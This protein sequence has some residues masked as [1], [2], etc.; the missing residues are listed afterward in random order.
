MVGYLHGGKNLNNQTQLRTHV[1][2]QRAF[3]NHLWQSS[4]VNHCYS[5]HYQNPKMAPVAIMIKM[6]ILIQLLTHISLGQTSTLTYG[7]WSW[8]TDIVRNHQRN[9][10]QQR[11]LACSQPP[12]VWP[13]FMLTI[14][15]IL[16]FYYQSSLKVWKV[17]TVYFS[18]NSRFHISS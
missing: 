8:M 3:D 17:G 15:R 18:S 16:W 7:Q 2:M 10:R 4:F 12:C 13:S 11:T 9:L 6:G 5:S 14:T 1:R